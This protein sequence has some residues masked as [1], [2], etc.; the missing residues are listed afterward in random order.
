MN[1]CEFYSNEK[2]ARLFLLPYF[3]SVNFFVKSKTKS[4]GKKKF[5]FINKVINT[6]QTKTKFNAPTCRIM[7]F[8][9][10]YLQISFK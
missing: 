6:A 1:C 5:Y 10:F 2:L 4:Y 9:A 7:L 3:C 8:A